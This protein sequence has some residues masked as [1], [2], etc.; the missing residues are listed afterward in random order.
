MK[1]KK[2][3]GF[4]D[5]W[6]WGDELIDPALLANDKN[7]H[8]SWLQ[9]TPYRERNC[10]LGLLGKHYSVPTENFGIPG[11]SLQSTIWTFLWWLRHEPNPSE[12]LVLTGLTEG[13][14][15]SF[16]N[17]NHQ[18][19]NNDPPWNKFVHSAWVHAG[20]DDG[21]VTR[22]WADMIKRYMVLSESDPLSLL[23]YEQALY[24][25]DGI[26][27][28]QNI[29]MLMWDISPPQE[30]LSVPTKIWPGFNFVHW[31][32]RHPNEQELTFPGGHPNEKGHLILRDMLQDE[33][34]CVI[35]SQ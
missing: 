25:F 20:V 18:R 4:G 1:F 2:I 30:E 22:D 21:P 35:L 7:A 24:T 10:F 29:P 15:M 11:G 5:S 13:S 19:M 17:P 23:N 26:A 12:C 28:R 8:P 31:L 32:R 16:F 9:N 34:D 14:R 33:I 27:A 6:I 3:V